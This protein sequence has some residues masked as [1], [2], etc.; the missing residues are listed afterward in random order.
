MTTPKATPEEIAAQAVAERL[1]IDTTPEPAQPTDFETLYKAQQVEID[2]LK[3]VIS[4]ARLNGT[5]SASKLDDRKPSVTAERFK[6]M[7]DP[8][9]FLR[10]TRN[11]KLAGIGVDPASVSDERL[12][13]LFGRGNNGREASELHKLNPY[14]YKILREAAEILNLYAA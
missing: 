7:V 10:M 14:R 8:V 11:E 2:D 6:R 4:A 13:A 12:K 9:A 1:G 5:G 3:A